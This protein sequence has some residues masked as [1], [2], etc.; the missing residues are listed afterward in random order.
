LI[1][2]IWTA[3]L[4]QQCLLDSRHDRVIDQIL[5]AGPATIRRS[6]HISNTHIHRCEID[7]PYNIIAS[8]VSYGEVY[9]I[10]IVIKV[11]SRK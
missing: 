10:H 3:P 7:A 1:A 4:L 8:Y 9:E 2:R 6:R 11:I 5:V